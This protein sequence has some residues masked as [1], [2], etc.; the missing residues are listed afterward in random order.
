MSKAPDAFRTISEVAELLETP[1]HVL[2][3]WESKF[4]QVR[5]VKRAGGRRYYRPG[6]VALL[7]GIRHLL[8]D[9]GLTI[10]GV[11]KLLGEKGARHVADLCPPEISGGV[12]VADDTKPPLTEPT[13]SVPE[14]ATAP[15]SVGDAGMPSPPVPVEAAADMGAKGA[16]ELAP[17]DS[18]EAEGVAPA[19]HAA[20][21][22]EAAPEREAEPA[23]TPPDPVPQTADLFTAPAPKAP[24]EA[25]PARPVPARTDL[26]A[27]A[28]RLRRVTPWDATALSPAERSQVAAATARLRAL[29]QRR[30]E[31]QSALRS[32]SD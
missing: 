14:P 26:S 8:H 31:A 2:R 19:P 24:P 17:S 1:Q 3:F 22:P 11:R 15:D 16:H 4:P 9:E 7:G 13:A 23:A 12:P 5:P 21:T 10:R 18:A 6:D 27:L 30:S 20:D 32:A 29:H 25:P 28:R